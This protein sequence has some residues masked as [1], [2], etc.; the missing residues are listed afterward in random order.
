MICRLDW[1]RNFKQFSRFFVIRELSKADITEV[2][3]LNVLVNFTKEEV[4]NAN[5]ELSMVQEFAK[6]NPET[7]ICY[8]ILNKTL[9]FNF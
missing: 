2:L 3:P 4:K 7:Q 9:Y 5:D 6:E 8:Q 1:E